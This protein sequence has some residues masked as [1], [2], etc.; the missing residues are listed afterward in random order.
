M[1]KLNMTPADVMTLLAD[2]MKDLDR[3]IT[4]FEESGDGLP[5]PAL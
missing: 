5:F 3:Q 2:V 4:E 1:F